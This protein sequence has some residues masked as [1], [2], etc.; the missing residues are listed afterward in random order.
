LKSVLARPG[1]QRARQ[2]GVAFVEALIIICSFV[3]FTIGLVFFF[4]LYTK[5]LKIAR[6]ARAS[7]MAYAMGGCEAN[8]PL[9]WAKADLPNSTSTSPGT[10]NNKQ[11]TRESR[12]VPGGTNGG[13]KAKSIVSSLPGT[14]DDGNIL[15]PVGSV[16]MTVMVETQSKPGPL[17]TPTGF[18]H[19]VSSTS[20]VTCNDKV[21]KGDFGEI[22]DYVTK[23]F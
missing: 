5:K 2:R 20:Y 10:A 18:K 13:E 6:A 8:N 21:R 1:R 14:G 11:P 16:G 3:L 4:N 22:V 7:A 23:L 17:A 12:G 19:S 9:D 15:N